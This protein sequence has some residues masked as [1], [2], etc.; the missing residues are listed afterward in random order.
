MN[1]TYITGILLMAGFLASCKITTQ[2]EYP[3]CSSPVIEVR[4]YSPPRL[5]IT[6][7]VGETIIYRLADDESNPDDLD[8]P[9]STSSTYTT[10][11]TLHFGEP[12]VIKA[13]AIRDGWA[14]SKV[15]TYVYIPEVKPSGR[16]L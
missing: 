7:G 12:Y 10:T 3:R 2:I 5:Y 15:S 16:H 14:N 11:I 13:V 4:D 6:A 8:D 9:N 1:K